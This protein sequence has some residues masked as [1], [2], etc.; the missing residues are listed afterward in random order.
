MVYTFMLN[1]I[2]VEARIYSAAIQKS[3]TAMTN[4]HYTVTYFNTNHHDEQKPTDNV[5]QKIKNL[6]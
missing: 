2:S 3:Q 5:L 6:M 1:H 4:Y